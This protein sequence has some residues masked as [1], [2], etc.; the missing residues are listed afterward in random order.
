MITA[1]RAQVDALV[2]ETPELGQRV[3][4]G[5]LHADA[6]RDRRRLQHRSD[7][8]AELLLACLAAQIADRCG[9]FVGSHHSRGDGVLE[10]V[11]HV[12]DAI[13]PTHDFALGCRGSRS[14]P[15]VIANPVEGFG[16]QIQR[17][18]SDV[19]APHGMVETTVDV[20]R[21][22]V[23]ARV[24]TGAVTA[25]VTE[26]DRLG[27]SDIETE[28]S[29]DRDRDLSD[30]ESVSE[31]RALVIVGKDEDLSL[32]GQ[33][34]ERGGVKDAISIA[35]ETGSVRI[36]LLRDDSS[37]GADRPS[38][39]SGQTRVGGVFAGLTIED[40]CFTASSP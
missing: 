38:G 10:V 19:G 30:F 18:E 34:T 16:A 23:F 5:G 13:G 33:P 3:G 12:G 4:H 20:R 24:T 25:I 26:G 31:A 27:E 14:A 21:Q 2:V 7:E 32:A 6:A 29:R 11:A 1:G 40:S 28:G 8:G 35:F 22:S 9:K 15:G 39:Q 17:N 36:G 37:S